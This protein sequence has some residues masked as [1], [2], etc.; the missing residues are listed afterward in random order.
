MKDTDIIALFDIRDEQAITELQRKYGESCRMAAMRVLNDE[1]DAEE[2]VNDAYLK[3]WNSIPPAIPEKLGTYVT[4]IVRNTAIDRLRRKN[5][6]KSAPAGGIVSTDDVDR[7][8]DPVTDPWT[9][10]LGIGK[11]ST[12]AMIADGIDPDGERVIRLTEEY[13][14]SIKLKNRKMF[15]AR[16]YYERSI[17]D[18]A[19]IMNVPKGTV[20]SNLKRTREGL[21]RF[22]ESRGIEV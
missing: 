2:C 13:L 10:P 22:L 4:G 20:L 21:R 11:G 6:Q 14:R 15:F 18:I 7:F 8:S 16:Y 5:T 19:G 3:V 12:G 17:D 1:S 9:D